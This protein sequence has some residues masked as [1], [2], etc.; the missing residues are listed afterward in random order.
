MWLQGCKGLGY[1][2]CGYFLSCC[3]HKP[4]KVYTDSFIV[5]NMIP[6]SGKCIHSATEL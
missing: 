2:I 1:M 3:V 5:G 6:K 4:P